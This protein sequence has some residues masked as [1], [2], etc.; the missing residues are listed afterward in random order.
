MALRGT[1][2]DRVMREQG[3]LVIARVAAAEA[4]ARRGQSGGF[5]REKSGLV[6][7]KE[8]RRPDGSLVK[9]PLFARGGSLGI[10]RLDESGEP[11]FVP[12]ERVQVMRRGRPGNFR[13]YGRYRLPDDYGAGIITVRHGNTP[14]DRD[15]RFN[16]AENLRPI[17]PGD[18]DFERLYRRRRDAES[19]NR[20]LKDTLFLRRAH[21]VGHLRQEADLLGFAL[22]VNSLTRA[23]CRDPAR[24]L[25]A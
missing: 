19:I 15:R 24:P 3:W 20:L 6:E 8:I 21:S 13:F 4:R 1:H 7:V 17:P 2:I 14:E 12:L 25:A 18:P 22:L 5:R 10:S 23:R 11:V 9:V 16:R